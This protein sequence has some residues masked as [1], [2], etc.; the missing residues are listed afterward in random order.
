ELA[1]RMIRSPGDRPPPAGFG[2]FGIDWPQRTRGLGTYD[3][4]WLEHDFPGFARDIDWR[5]HNVAPE[6]QRFEELFAPGQ[7]FV[8]HNLVE[9][10]SRVE[11]SIP[12]VT[13]RC[14][15]WRGDEEGRALSEVP[16]ALRT[17]WLVPDEDMMV[18]V[19]HG[20]EPV[21]SMLASEIRGVLCALDACDRP[22]DLEHFG[23]ALQKRLD[24]ELG[25]AEMLDDRPLMPEGMDF[26]DF[27]A[28]AEDLTLPERS[29]ALEA[30]L[31]AGAELRR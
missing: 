29:G 18:L 21:S 8:L 17:L 3:A 14:F 7:L 6:D 16:L 19:F 5:V 31:Y 9:G 30:N 20:A 1:G 12:R 24:R 25:A 15:V 4:T 23:R 22:R 2:A 28:R 13:A 26:P 10:R 27:A 11:L